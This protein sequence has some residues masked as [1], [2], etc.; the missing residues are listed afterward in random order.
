M[1]RELFKGDR[2]KPITDY[3]ELCAI[4]PPLILFQG[5]VGLASGNREG[6]GW[7]KNRL[8]LCG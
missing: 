5:R 2:S 4:L 7:G 6:Y 8:F 3:S 1:N